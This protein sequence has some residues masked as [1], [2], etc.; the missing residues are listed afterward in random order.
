M[1]SLFKPIMLIATVMI[2]TVVTSCSN[3]DDSGTTLPPPNE[4]VTEEDLAAYLSNLVTAEEI[5][6][7]SVSVAAR[8]Q[9]LFQQSFG[10]ANIEEQT[11]YSNT[12]VN[13]IASISKTFIAAA[14]VKAI[15]QGYFTLDTNIKDLLPIEITNPKRPEHDIK[16][17]HLVTH[18]SGIVD[19]IETYVATNYY[20]LP[21]EDIHT[22]VAEIMINELGIQQRE[23][24]T[25]EA[26]LA[27]FFEEDGEFY[28]LDTFL[29]AAPG[30]QWQYS[31]IGA[32]LMSFII[33]HVT[34]Q[35]F[36]DY[37]MEHI[38]NPLQMT[39]S[40]YNLYD[41]NL[42]NMATQY[43][44][45]SRPF[46]RYGNHSY[47]EGSMYTTNNDLGNYLLEM[48]RGKRGENASL[49]STEYFDLLFQERLD[50]GMIPIEFAEN[51]G[52]FWFTNNE[53]LLHAGN[54][55]GVSSDLQIKKDGSSGYIIVTNMDGT[56]NQNYPKWERTKQLIADAI[57]QFISNN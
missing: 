13:S 30:E 54:S 16:I 29:D 46:P 15:S 49:F 9:L 3:D 32:S 52:I 33:E 40:T 1:K 22:S 43:L 44:D 11:P 2:L 31:N 41:V 26:Y 55:L 19:V 47:A 39:H 24:V 51:Q 8:N 53:S 18:T 4:I 56:F 27:A 42:S 57:H 28:S 20:I 48:M 6:G 23:P 7:F 10:Y 37:V 34:G 38:L 14:T 35:S 17:K 50:T 45:A 12:T 25:L 21:N 5:P 36:D